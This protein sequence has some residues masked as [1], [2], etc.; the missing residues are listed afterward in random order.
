MRMGP[1]KRVK[2][3]N[4]PLI[5]L[6]TRYSFYGKIENEP[7]RRFIKFEM[8][9]CVAFVKFKLSPENIIK[10]KPSWR[11]IYKVPFHT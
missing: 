5:N 9:S 11:Q 10:I 2:I 1:V 6:R 3:E 8:S 4:Q 7:P